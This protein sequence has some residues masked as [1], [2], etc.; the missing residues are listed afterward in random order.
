MLCLLGL[1]NEQTEGWGEVTGR[2][3]GQSVIKEAYP[4]LLGELSGGLEA[5]RSQS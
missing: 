5:L 2:G 4:A 1:V 3:E